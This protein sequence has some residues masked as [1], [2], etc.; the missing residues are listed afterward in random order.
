MIWREEGVFLASVAR[1]LVKVKGGSAS[2]R[3]GFRAGRKRLGGES[4]VQMRDAPAGIVTRTHTPWP[5]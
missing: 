2:F 4:F 5:R 3:R 1:A